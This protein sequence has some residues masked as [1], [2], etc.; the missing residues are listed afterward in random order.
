[1]S[2]KINAGENI[3]ARRKQLETALF[4]AIA[5]ETNKFQEETGLLVVGLEA[6][7]TTLN[8][9]SIGCKPTIAESILTDV[10]VEVKV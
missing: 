8:G 1:M 4:R 3:K 9:F 7:F 2:S 6:T 10:R 5:A